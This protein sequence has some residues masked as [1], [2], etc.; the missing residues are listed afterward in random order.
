ML[1]PNASTGRASMKRVVALGSGD[2]FSSAGRGNTCWLVE[3]GA[4][5]CAVDFGPTAVFALRRLGRDPQELQAVHFTHL[6]GDHI[7]GWPFLLV[8]AVYRARRTAALAASGPPGTRERLEA[9]WSACYADAAAKELP[10]PLV[11]SELQPGES[12]QIAGRRVEALRA[13]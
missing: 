13:Q 7:A 6:H 3:D 9:L 12:A 1:A 5:L 11:V 8:D 2:A 4:P 10:F